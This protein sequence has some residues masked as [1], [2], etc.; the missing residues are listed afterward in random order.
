MRE[1]QGALAARV[2]Q[3]AAQ[4][5]HVWLVSRVD[6]QVLGFTDHDRDLVFEG[7]TCRA[8]SGWSMGSGDASVGMTPGGFSVS[9]ALDD[10][11]L[12]EEDIVAGRYDEAQVA[13]WRVDWSQTS[14]RAQLWGG[15]LCGLRREGSGFVGD[16]EGPMAQLDRVVG[17]T[18]GRDC[19]AVLGDARCGL[20]EGRIAGRVCNRTWRTCTQVFGNGM[21]FRGFPDVPGDDF[22]MARPMTGMRHDGGTRR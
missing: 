17:R 6:G 2:E 21:N 7:V 9:G 11:A 22:V 5:C 13:L 8:A 15:T 4:L 1:L 20:D 19:D 18:Y 10:A 3:G 14:A 12:T 16:L